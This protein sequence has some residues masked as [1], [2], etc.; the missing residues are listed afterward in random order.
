MQEEF[1]VLTYRV[2]GYL[3]LGIVR[4]YSKKVEYLF[5]DCQ[6]VLIGVNNF[7]VHT[8][9]DLPLDTRQAP[10]FAVTLPETFE[11]DALDLEVLDIDDAIG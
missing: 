1:P 2:L 5:E 10:Y 3:L 8:I 4:I 11:L 6:E 7:V 9:E